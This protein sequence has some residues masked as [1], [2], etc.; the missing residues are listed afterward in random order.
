MGIVVEHDL[1]VLGAG[2]ERGLE[3]AGLGAD[4]GLERRQILAGAVDDL[5]ELQLLAGQLLDQLGYLGAELAERAGYLVRGVEQGVAL[6]RQ[7]LDQAA[8]LALVLLVGAFERGDLVVHQRLELAGAAERTTDGIVHERDLAAHRLTERGDGLLRHAVG[9]GETHRDLG[10][11]ARAQPQLLRTPRHQGKAVEQADRTDQRRQQ[12]EELRPLRDG[13]DAGAAQHVLAEVDAGEHDGDDRP[14]RTGAGRDM[15][16]PHR[17]PLVQR[18][19]QAA[20]R[21]GVVVGRDAIARRGGGTA[22]GG[23]ATAGVGDVVIVRRG[24][25]GFGGLHRCGLRRRLA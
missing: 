22:A 2:A 11:R 17:G 6:G 20:D 9:L 4:R 1:Q 25:V 19:D 5:G 18:I 14:G 8:D 12:R 15:E 13:N 16:R 3:I 23:A 10:H 7:L 21:G 24:K